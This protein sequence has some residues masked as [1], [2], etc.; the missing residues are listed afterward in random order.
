M[1]EPVEGLGGI[2]AHAVG[3]VALGKGEHEPA[4][5]AQAGARFVEPAFIK[6]YM[7]F[8]E[9]DLSEAAGA[10]MA[11]R[12]RAHGLGCLAISAH[13]D[14]GA[15]EAAEDLARRLRFT[16]ALGAGITI[17]N[18]TSRPWRDALSSVVGAC[19]PLAESLGVTI[20]L[21]NP[22]HG[23]DDLMPDGR[24]GAEL[25]AAFA[26]PW[27]RLNY[28]TGNTRTHSEGAVR[29]EDD[30]L[31]T[32]PTLCHVHLKDVSQTPTG[33]RYVA[34]GEGELGRGRIF[35]ALA[36]RPEI[37]VAIEI[38]LRLVRGFAAPARRDPDLPALAAI[39]EAVRKSLR[40]RRVYEAA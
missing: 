20:A 28:D 36:S 31:H 3:G 9:T 38:P 21:E 29:P 37:P 15:P 34:I 8:D 23:D 22:G 18:S 24:R 10:A 4:Q 7:D 14:Q 40:T 33:W 39:S 6:G 13:M 25:V 17:T 1:A 26:S 19:L 5:T 27:L 16:A 11:T 32:L 12:L 35:K 2:E 30:I